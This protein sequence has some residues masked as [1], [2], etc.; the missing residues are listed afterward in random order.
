MLDH[1]YCHAISRSVTVVASVDRV[2]CRSTN[3]SSRSRRC[4]AISLARP[5][6]RLPALSL[7]QGSQ[8]LGVFPAVFG[9]RHILQGSGQSQVQGGVLLAA[10]QRGLADPVGPVSRILKCSL[11]KLEMRISALRSDAGH[12][13]LRKSGRT[14]DDMSPIVAIMPLNNVES[15]RTGIIFLF[16]HNICVSS[17]GVRACVVN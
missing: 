14:Y 15:R 2:P 10:G 12:F 9:V 17:F 5:C 7:G 13:Q 16:V 11:E 4:S 3:I 6:Y 1:Q 8:E